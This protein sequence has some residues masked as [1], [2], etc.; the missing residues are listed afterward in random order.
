MPDTTRIGIP[1]C[2]IR[3]ICHVPVGLVSVLGT[4][5]Y[6]AADELD[7]SIFDVI[8]QGRVF[9]RGVEFVARAVC[10]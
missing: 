4:R 1:S 9:F 7:Q 6:H 2:A 10:L 5:L 8:P 3:L